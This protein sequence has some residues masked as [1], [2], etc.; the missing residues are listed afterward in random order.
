MKTTTPYPPKA[1]SLSGRMKPRPQR[2]VLNEWMTCRECEI[3]KPWNEMHADA[4][5]KSGKRAL[6]R[7]CAKNAGTNWEEYAQR[8]LEEAQAFYGG[9]AFTYTETLWLLDKKVIGI[10]GGFTT[11]APILRHNQHL[12][13]GGHIE[14]IRDWDA[15][16]AL[17]EA[18]Q[19]VKP[20]RVTNAKTLFALCGTAGNQILR[21][22]PQQKVFAHPS[23][24]AAAAAEKQLIRY[25]SSPDFPIAAQCLNTLHLWK[26][27]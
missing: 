11:R 20:T 17:L 9:I 25:I 14:E 12:G 6:C 23:I 18:T 13:S 1:Y 26:A 4:N 22:P 3:D 21:N 27:G 2:Y 24:D 16:K 15:D 5:N 7:D 19:L 8:K 10:Y